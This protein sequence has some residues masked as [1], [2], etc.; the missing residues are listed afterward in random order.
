MPA[1]IAVPAIIG[2]ASSLGGA[3]ISA[4]ASGR[5]A[6]QQTQAADRAAAV[7]R[8]VY[9][10]QMALAQ[11]YLQAG[12]GSVSALG[13][14]LTPSAGA[15][16]ASE[17]PGTPQLGMGP[18]PRM[19]PG[20]QPRMGPGPD[21]RMG[22]SRPRFG[23]VLQQQMGGGP[24]PRL[25]DRGPVMGGGSVGGNG[26]GGM[27]SLRAPDGSIGQV[28]AHLAQQFIQRGATPVQ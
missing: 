3:A 23:D 15:R 10:Q 22:P 18:Q 9:Q 14:L 11:P 24:A 16:Y 26:G 13:R 7:Q 1:A 2:A 20:P 4:R 17:A 12:A 27:V 5:A 8:D 28:P 21:S 25:G 6:R 19:G